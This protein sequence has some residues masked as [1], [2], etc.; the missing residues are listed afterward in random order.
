MRIAA[1]EARTVV[2]PLGR[3]TRISRRALPNRHYTLTRLRAEDGTTGF[4]WCLGGA[5][6]TAAVRALLAPRYAGQ[7]VHENERLWDEAYYDTIL[8]GRRGAVVRAL[9]TVDVAL[10]DL[11]ARLLG[12]PLAR[13][14]GVYQDPVPAYASGG[15]Y[16]E[17]RDAELEV[18]EEASGWAEAGY[19]AMKL[20]VGGVPLEVDVKRLAAFRRTV[21]DGPRLM[22][23]ANNAWRDWRTALEAI[24]R[25][26]EF[27]IEWI[28]E[29]LSP[30]DVEGHRRLGEKLDTRIATGEIE[31]TR[32]GFAQLLRER[33]VDVIQADAAVVGGITEWRRIAAT[34]ASFDVPL[35]PHWFADLHVHCVASAPNGGWIEVFPDTRILNVMELFD[36]RLEVRDGFAPV[37]QGPGLGFELDGAAVDRFAVDAWG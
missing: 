10:W 27:G 18:E 14:L 2:V 29:P 25:F 13:L 24:R 22:L 17:D 19:T 6:V 16:Y 7:D 9:S 33:A 36:R 4:G 3:P 12:L 23:D 11:K 5:T 37:P 21:G 34:A 15:Y 31:A 20:K 28:E 30:D 32:W 1:V 26:E 8:Q 35:A